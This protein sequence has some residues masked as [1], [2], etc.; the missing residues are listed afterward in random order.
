VTGGTGFLGYHI[1][2]QLLSLGAQ[3]RVLA[4]PPVPD[5][6][7]L[8]LPQVETTYGDLLDPLVVRRALANCSVIFHAA[9]IVAVSGPQL[10]Q[11]HAVHVTSTNNVLAAAPPNS[12]IVHTSSLVAVG[13]SR[14]ADVLDEDSPFNLER[15][16]IDYVHAKRA[17]EQ[18]ALVAAE[19]GQHVVV[20]NPGYLVGPEDPGKSVMG[21]LCQRYWKGR[22]PVASPGGLN[23]VDVR[24]VAHGHLLAAE[25]GVAGRRYILGGSNHT[26]TE[27]MALL[28]EAAGFR[29]RGLPTLPAW[30]LAG[31]ARLAQCRAFFTGKEPFP[32]L[33]QVRLN[34]YYWYARSDRAAGELG[35]RYRP[36]RETLA[37]TYHWYAREGLLSLRGI[38]RWWMR[39]A[40]QAT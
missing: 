16:R 18:T 40:N 26:V 14:C 35:Y 12:R 20:V 34:R 15:C 24:D 27:F 13:G 32:S 7:L 3:V 38:N 36:L 29:P 30:L 22:L 11:M 33:Q 19:R 28:A 39:P 1:V 17:A 9:G 31:V 5:H 23:L 25:H 8:H 6:P 21:R 10:R 37:D 4:L 2:R